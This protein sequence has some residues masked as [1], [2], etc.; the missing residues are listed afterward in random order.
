MRCTINDALSYYCYTPTFNVLYTL[1]EFGGYVCCVVNHMPFV[2]FRNL[3]N[4]QH[5]SV[6]FPVFLSQIW[7]LVLNQDKIWWLKSFSFFTPCRDGYRGMA[8]FPAQNQASLSCDRPKPCT[9]LLLPCSVSTGS[10]SQGHWMRKPRSECIH[11]W[12]MYLRKHKQLSS[13][14]TSTRP[15]MSC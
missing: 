3:Q 2:I 13:T 7:A 11:V 5:C 15:L 8:T 14:C 9:Q 12:W 6:I 10:M 4:V 1:Q